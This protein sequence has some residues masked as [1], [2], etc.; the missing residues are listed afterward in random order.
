MNTQ[1][2]QKIAIFCLILSTS[3]SFPISSI[4]KSTGISKSTALA[5]PASFSRISLR[6]NTAT[7]FSCSAKPRPGDL[8]ASELVKYL[9]NEVQYAED[10][11]APALEFFSDD[12]IYEDMIYSEPFRGKAQVTSFLIN[13]KEKAPED[14]VFVLDKC[15]DGV[16][17][18]GFTWHIELKTRPDAGRFAN[19]CSFYELNDDGKICYVRDIPEP[20][21]KIGSFGLVLANLAAKA[22]KSTPP[23]A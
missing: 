15:S 20:P 9:W 18:C 13:T 2:K 8:T 6:R 4:F 1:T 12:V 17:S 22:I 21:L 14:F 19:G 11:P 7:K 23:P 16:K 10:Y 3:S 5:K